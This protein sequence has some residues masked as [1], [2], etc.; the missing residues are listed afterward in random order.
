MENKMKNRMALLGV[1]IVGGIVAA[2]VGTAF[3]AGALLQSGTNISS[4]VK[5][6]A[7]GTKTVTVKHDGK[8]VQES[9][10]PAGSGPVVIQSGSDGKIVVS[11]P[12]EEEMQK[13]DAEAEAN[14][15]QLHKET[16]DSGGS[17]LTC[18]EEGQEVDCSQVPQP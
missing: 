12:T 9:T 14:G 15:G 17:G 16:E 3:G 2:G 11:Q 7:D 4:D 5:T 13:M 18:Y 6:N 8:V 1:L 10:L